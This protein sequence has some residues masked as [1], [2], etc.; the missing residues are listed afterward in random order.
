ML[1]L[2]AIVE[3]LRDALGVEGLAHASRDNSRA[4]LCFFL[5]TEGQFPQF[6]RE[7]FAGLVAMQAIEARGGGFARCAL[8]PLPC[9]LFVGCVDIDDDVFVRVPGQFALDLMHGGAAGH[10]S[11]GIRTAC[12]NF[13]SAL[14][15]QRAQGIALPINRNRQWRFPEGIPAQFLDEERSEVE[16]FEVLLDALSVGC[17]R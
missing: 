12:V 10:L 4:E 1:F 2:E 14:L 11:F 7:Q 13:E 17:H 8:D 16:R 9:L 15:H 3:F 6:L 5:D